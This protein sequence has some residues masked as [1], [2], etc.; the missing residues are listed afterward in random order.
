[1]QEGKLRKRAAGTPTRHALQRTAH[2]W[3][4]PSGRNRSMVTTLHHLNRATNPPGPPQK[5]QQKC[6]TVSQART[7]MRCA[8]TLLCGSMVQG[9]RSAFVWKRGW[10]LTCA[11]K[12]HS[13]VHTAFFDKTNSPAHTK[14]SLTCTHIDINLVQTMPGTTNSMK[15][16]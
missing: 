10:F 14:D 4:Y 6:L 1:M 13:P 8:E 9:L 12:I 7:T 15:R 2:S 3:E 16:R 11:R 5:F